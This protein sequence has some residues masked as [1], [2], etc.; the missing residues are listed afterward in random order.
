MNQQQKNYAMQRVCEK[1]K[2]ILVNA[3]NLRKKSRAEVSA[4]ATMTVG[5]ILDNFPTVKEAS[6][7]DLSK[8]ATLH[9]VFDLSDVQAIVDARVIQATGQLPPANPRRCL[10]L[11]HPVS[12]KA[13]LS[14]HVE[15]NFEDEFRR[16]QAK[17]TRACDAIM[18]GDS[19]EANA[20]IDNF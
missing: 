14:M 6:Q 20:V 7:D 15:A 18:L 3:I 12:G 2:A 1:A 16:V 17:L 10:N 8:P 13:L 11:V 19:A 4:M 5:D 9:S